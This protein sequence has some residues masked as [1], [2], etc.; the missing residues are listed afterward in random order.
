[1]RNL[2]LVLPL[3]VLFAFTVV[4]AADGDTKPAG[5]AKPADGAKPLFGMLDKAPEGKADIAA[6]LKNR[7]GDVYNLVTTSDEIKKKIADLQC[8]KV[9]VKGSGDKDKYTVDSI[10]EAKGHKKPDDSSK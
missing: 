1:M 6:T 9:M 4:R 7:K 10:E 3:A 2:K 5:D 8:K